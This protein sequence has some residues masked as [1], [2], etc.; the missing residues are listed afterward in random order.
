MSGGAARNPASLANL[1]RGASC[2]WLSHKQEPRLVA[3][4]DSGLTSAVIA[5]RFETTRNAVI[6][7]LWRMKRLT[8][9]T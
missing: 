6:G 3:L 8:Q 1:V 9:T 4:A 5:E 2:G 7:K